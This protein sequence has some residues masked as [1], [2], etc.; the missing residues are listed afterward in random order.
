MNN[1]ISWAIRHTGCETAVRI[2]L[3]PDVMKHVI[4]FI[5]HQFTNAKNFHSL[6]SKDNTIVAYLSLQFM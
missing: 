5:E 6:A 1:A 4:P 2:T 3:Q